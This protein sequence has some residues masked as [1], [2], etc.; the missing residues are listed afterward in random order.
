M[1]TFLV[2]TTTGGSFQVL[3]GSPPED[4]AEGWYDEDTVDCGGISLLGCGSCVASGIG[5]G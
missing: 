3:D 2:F 5:G 1:I 4:G